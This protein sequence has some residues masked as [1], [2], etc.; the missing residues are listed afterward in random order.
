MTPLPPPRHHHPPARRQPAHDGTPRRPRSARCGRAA[1]GAP[2]RTP[3]AA[4]RRGPDPL[5][6]PALHRRHLPH[7]PAAGPAVRR[8]S[9]PPRP[10]R[11]AAH[12][13][14]GPAPGD[15][16]PRRP[17]GG[18]TRRSARHL[19]TACRAEPGRCGGRPHRHELMG[20][21]LVTV[22]PWAVRE[23][24]LL[25]CIEDGPE[26][27]QTVLQDTHPATSGARSGDD[28]TRTTSTAAPASPRTCLQ[29]VRMPHR[30]PRA[31]EF[32]HPSTLDAEGSAPGRAARSVLRT[33]RVS[34][35]PT[36][37]SG[38]TT[39]TPSDPAE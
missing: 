19:R 34:T 39:A 32:D 17:A 25:R 31:P 7:L 22:C 8:R 30:C 3:S 36:A 6:G 9:G 35:P 23:G 1:G 18:R 14:Q 27:W 4:G 10:L 33:G 20:L 28:G 21:R 11:P 29:G 5:G 12:A 26:W 38:R 2:P 16:H 13:P 15:H 37:T 24:V